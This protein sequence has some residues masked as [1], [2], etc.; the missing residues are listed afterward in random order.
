M[1]ARV[2]LTK[3]LQYLENDFNY[4]G[5]TNTT[6]VK[7][8]LYTPPVNC[9]FIPL[10]STGLINRGAWWLG[11]C[12]Y[13]RFGRC[14]TLRPVV[15]FVLPCLTVLAGRVLAYPCGDPNLLRSGLDFF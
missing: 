6:F 2:L 5:P 14:A 8:I 11:R 3:V 9:A 4:V 7:S 13:Y 10:E 12:M 15:L 1:Y